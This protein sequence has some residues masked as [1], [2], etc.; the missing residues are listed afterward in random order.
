MAETGS[1]KTGSFA[2]P[3]LEKL[4]S[5][6]T[7]EDLY[8]VLSPTR[9]L[10]QQTHK[11]FCQFG[12]P[13][14]FYS[15]CLIGGESFE[16]QKEQLDKKPRVLVATPGRFC[17]SLKQKLI[18]LTNCAGVVFDEADRLFDMGFQKDIEFI[19]DNIR[20]DRQLIMVSATT[21]MEV[22]TT[23]YKYNSHPV[24]LKLNE[25]DNMLVDNINH[26]V[27]MIKDDE[28]MSFLIT[29]LRDFEDSYGIIFCNTQYMT[30]LVAAW[31]QKMNFKVKAISGKMPQNKRTKLMEEFRSKEIT[32]LVCTDVAA[33]GLDI[34][35]V[36][37]V[38]NYDLP[39]EAASYVHRIGRT[40]RAGKTGFAISLCGFSDCANLDAIQTYIKESIPK[41]EIYD[42]DF[43]TD[44]CRRPHIDPKT[45]KVLES[46]PRK[47]HKKTKTKV[48]TKTDKKK[49]TKKTDYIPVPKTFEIT[50]TCE[51]HAHE[52]ALKYFA[53]LEKSLLKMEVLEVGRK[54]FFFFGPQKKK[55]Q[56]SVRP[57]FKKLLT[58]F[59]M[60]T[61]KKMGLNVRVRVSYKEP[62]VRA[63]FFGKDV[64]LLMKN[65]FEL[66]NALEHLAIQYI[67]RK[68]ALA[69]DTKFSF[70]SDKKDRDEISEKDLI[71]LAKETKE[72]V[73]K[74]NK[75]V[76]IKSLN[77]AHRRIIHQYINEDPKFSS[78][79]KGEGRF[80]QIEISLN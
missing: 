58:P 10:A 15:A 36:N 33:R 7:N 61:I 59:L 27:A 78:S 52:Q 65:R 12:E 71:K 77:P 60:E 42:D 25:N 29:L 9:E 48:N 34:K 75:P 14:G 16:K 43:A 5:D 20:S 80:K 73:E 79:S 40:G 11:V 28:K 44:L 63:N 54:K 74:Q 13:L 67:R 57:I 51:N 70:K 64:G 39:N 53:I 35:G 2:I 56:F 4:L 22:L 62:V 47:E 18:D 8:V 66:Q 32:T 24:E 49:D 26:E 55:Y 21:N 46:K 17:D 45:Y 31:L 76:L 19:L 6:E 69:P 50:S 23:A 41:A 72:K 30:H 37:L 38:V 3:I 68:I 1:G